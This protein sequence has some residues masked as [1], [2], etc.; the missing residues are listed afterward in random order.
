M[1]TKKTILL[2]RLLCGIL[3]SGLLLGLCACGRKT[4]QNGELCLGIDVA[5]YQG[6]IG[7][8]RVS[9]AGVKFAMVRLG[10][11]TAR[12][13]VI[14]E[15]GN[16]RYNLQEAG[17]AGIPVGAY[18]FS[19]ATNVEEA[20]EEAQWVAQL[21]AKYPITYP[22]AY[23][24]EG[25]DDP[26]SRQ[27]G[28][29]VKERT[30]VALAFLKEIKKLGYEGMFYASKSELEERWETKRIAKQ[31]KI[32][33]A[34]YPE[35]PYPETY[36]PDYDGEYHM[37]QYSKSFRIPGITTEVDMNLANFAYNGIEPPKDPEPPEEAYPDPEAMMRF[38]DVEETVT[39]KERTNLRNIPSQG[40]ESSVLYTLLNG[41]TARRTAISDAGWSRL[42]YDGKVCYAVSNF[43]T[44]DLDY[45]PSTSGGSDG[46]KTQFDNTVETVTAK[47]TVNLR[48]IPSVESEESQV[49]G[50]LKNGEKAQRTGISGNGWSRLVWNGTTC[51]AVSNYL[52]LLDA[53]GN[54]VEVE[55]DEIKTPFE[56]IDDFV[57]PKEKVNLRT[58]PS[59]DN[60]ACKVAATITSKDTVR[61]TGIN[62]DVGWSRVEY[63]GQT[64]YCITK[65][66]K[67]VN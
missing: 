8:Q 6:T 35:K 44:T 47:D 14:T 23:D 56:D 1:A 31:F 50:Q 60:P 61:R 39:A 7:W 24:C 13:G 4:K 32:W 21:V 27:N 57:S 9:E 20:K 22:I 19:T 40:E 30:D 16:A 3:A 37:W 42:I 52:V 18:F 29:T 11:R 41:E 64:L 53:N 12:D 66:L 36:A 15:D 17:R 59:V 46:F 38:R 10:Y 48:T 25:Y 67:E 65:Y 43:L 63:E 58:M 5:R 55:T 51:Y 54:A 49:I 26:D 2:R 28:M 33:V 34:Q 45:D 62:R